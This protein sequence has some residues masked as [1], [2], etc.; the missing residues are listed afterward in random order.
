M[1]TRDILAC[2]F[3]KRPQ[4]IIRGGRVYP[5]YSEDVAIC[6]ECAGLIAERE[7][8]TELLE[9]ANRKA[10]ITKVPPNPKPRKARA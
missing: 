6:G 8:T 10:K 7:A 4:T 3:C 2:D 5:A 1:I 9:D